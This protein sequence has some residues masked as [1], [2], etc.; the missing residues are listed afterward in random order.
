[1][2]SKQIRYICKNDSVLRKFNI[3]I[4]LDS[5]LVGIAPNSIY[6]LLVKPKAQRK[7]KG[8]PL[9]FRGH[10]CLLESLDKEEVHFF[11]PSGMPPNSCYISKAAKMYCKQYNAKFYVNKIVYQLLGTSIC[12][13]ICV[14]V[15]LCRSRGMNYKKIKTE[16]LNHSLKFITQVL[17]DFFYYFLPK[18]NRIV[19]RFSY[20]FL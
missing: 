12:G 14:F 13:L 11:D 6:F 1:M 2:D 17:P 20:D 7:K 19:P 5:E 15:A 18:N 9:F 10:W 8:G 16:K 3:N 4:I